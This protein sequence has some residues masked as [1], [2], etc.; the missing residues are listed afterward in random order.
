M[1]SCMYESKPC[2]CMSGAHVGE[3]RMLGPLGLELQIIVSHQ[4][5]LEQNLGSLEQQVLLITESFLQP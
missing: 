1:F 3:K 5:V 4:A 2:A